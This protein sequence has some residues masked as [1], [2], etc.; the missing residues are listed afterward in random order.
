LT[1]DRIWSDDPRVLGAQSV[2]RLARLHF[3]SDGEGI[4]FLARQSAPYPFHV[5]RPFH[6]PGEAGM[7]T[8]YLQSCAGGVFEGD[9]L[10]LEL[11]AET[12][13]RAHVTTSA[14][15]IVHSMLNADAM[16]RVALHAESDALLEFLPDPLILFPDARLTSQVRVLLEPNATVLLSDAF[17]LHD[18]AARDGAFG[19]LRSEVLVED[20]SGGV[21]ALDRLQA[22]GAAVKAQAVGVTGTFT[23]QAS[24]YALRR[25]ADTGAL[26]TSLR[27]A[28][29]EVEGIFAGA[30]ALPNDAGVF[31]R[32]LAPDAI[33]LRAALQQAWIA[34]RTA[35]T[36][37]A[38]PLRRK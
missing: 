38:P 8:V 16:Q 21:L 36:G 22:N 10:E 31:A 30:S 23:A 5:C 24:F 37:A 35:L 7:A 2:G 11:H 32:I 1:G 34:A 20:E 29:E 28:L 14:S 19:A 15:T 18:P 33:T 3:A 13:A 6:L 12:G 25:N 9:R 26:L 4:T 17:L 27:A